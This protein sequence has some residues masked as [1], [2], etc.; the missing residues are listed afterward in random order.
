MQ[1]MLTSA[2]MSFSMCPLLNQGAV[3]MLLHHASEELR[4]TYLPKMVTGEWTGTMNLTEPQAGSDVGAL[5]TRATPQDDGT[6]RIT[7]TKI[8]IT[9]GE[10]DMSDNI[11][12]LVLA[13]TP[14]APPGTKGISCFIVPKLLVGDDGTLGQRNDVTCVSVE[15]KMGI[16]A[17]PTCVLSYGERGEGAI[18]HLIGE[19]NAGMRYMFTMMNNAR[20]SVGLQGLAVAERAFQMA[21]GYAKERRQ[22]RAP[23]APAGEQSTIV[24]HPDVRRMLLTQRACIEAL[25]GI[26][27]ANAA[28]IDR[29]ARHP[30]EQARARSA[31]LADIL[32]P[33]SK[34]W[35]TDLGVDLTSLALQVFGGMGY[36]EETGIA[37]LYRDARIAPIYE[38]TNGIQAMDLVGRKLPMRAGAAVADYLAAIEGALRP[39]DEAGADLASIRDALAAAL[40]S[41]RE[42]TDWLLAH[43]AQDPRD[44]LAGATPY[45][46]LFSLV[47]A[48][49]VMALQ[50]VTAH[51]L[52]AEAAGEDRAFYEG[53]VLTARFFC[54]QILPQAAGLVP[55]VTATNRDLAAAR[56]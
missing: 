46:R 52:L 22:G 25:R 35:G 29:A 23:G 5:T 54:E 18:G 26:I 30:D 9:F 1:E 49:W 53:K 39:L 20:L 45:L 51:A 36:I 13:R 40:A 34:G 44:A 32:T 8:F 56:L 47:T 7:G 6:Y 17:S 11:I 31:E 2:N 3:D 14:T 48:G 33:V 43:G 27:Y 4:E 55:A 12:H 38:G 15:H 16:K 42:A 37:Q 41:L 24:E 50:A 28:A 19:E 21:L 10:H